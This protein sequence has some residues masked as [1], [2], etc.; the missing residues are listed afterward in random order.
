MND[1]LL[2]ARGLSFAYTEQTV[3]DDINLSIGGGEILGLVG[4]DGAGKTTL[5]RL[6]V[7]QLAA[8]SGA[9]T[10]LGKAT[11]DPA[12]RN[13]IAYMPNIYFIYE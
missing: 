5:L 12:L 11:S 1:P 9:I 7:G 13:D 3:L 2:V 6:A 8:V 10:V 4:A